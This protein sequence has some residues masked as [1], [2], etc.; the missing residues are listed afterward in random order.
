MSTQAKMDPLLVIFGVG[1]IGFA[2]WALFA[3]ENMASQVQL[4]A[5]SAS[6]RN[7]LRANYGGQFLMFG[8]F[9]LIAA[10]TT[11]HRVS[12]YL[13]LSFAMAGL[14]LGR[15]YAML[16]DGVGNPFVTGLLG[17]EI[18]LFALCFWRY[19]SVRQASTASAS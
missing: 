2:L 15:T 18:V 9:F 19:R 3:T 11:V 10:R 7:E 13:I 6:S 1:F 5:D 17:V 14:A 8:V 4:V 16:M 12:A